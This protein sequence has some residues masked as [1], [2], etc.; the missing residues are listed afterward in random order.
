MMNKRALITGGAGFIGSNLAHRLL[1]EGWEVSV[2]DDLSS[3]KTDFVDIRAAM[4]IAD[5]A[6]PSLLQLI[7][8]KNYDVVFH[9]AAKPRV[10]YSVEYPA[11]TNDINVQRF[12]ALLEACKGNVR[13]FIN[14]SS[15]SVYGGANIL[16]TP[17]SH[18]HN[19]RS[20]YALQK[21]I[22]EQYC[23]LFY[24]LY[25][26]DSVSVRPFNVF[27]PHQ[28]GDNP[29]ACAV[30]AWLYAVKHG[31]PLRSD[32][33]GTQSRDITFVDNVVDIFVR[34]AESSLRFT[35]KEAFNAGTGFSIT[36][37]EVLQ[38]FKKEYP[39]TEINHANWRLGDVMKTQAD[40]DLSE[41]LLGY[42]PLVTFWDGLEKTVKWAFESELF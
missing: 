16:P 22:T 14:T 32:G 31:L 35:G 17:E 42:K 21:S 8:N 12:V 33:D 9:L 36:N 7:K 15:S 19:P 29:Y 3:G 5:F 28:L 40:I 1:N 34:C 37:N 6:D 20:P 27:G 2:V 41:K 39:K 26:L 4:Y 38:W 11:E 10:S 30:S 23:K 24:D 25:G 13:R 18:E